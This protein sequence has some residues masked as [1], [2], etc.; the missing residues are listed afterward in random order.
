MRKNTIS[1]AKSVL[2]AQEVL[3]EREVRRDSDHLSKNR[4]GK[5]RINAVHVVHVHAFVHS[6]NAGV[7]ST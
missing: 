4:E 6:I 5:V 1:T 3:L 7:K 2:Y